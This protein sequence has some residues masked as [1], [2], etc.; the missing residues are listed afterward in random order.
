MLRL[1]IGPFNAGNPLHILPIP[2]RRFEELLQEQAVGLGAEIRR[3]Q[4]VTGFTQD[5]DGVTVD[6]SAGEAASTVRARFLVG[7]DGA[8]SLVRK[9]AGIGFPG[10]TSDI[11]TRI[12]RVT[13]PPSKI[14]RTRDRGQAGL[15]IAGVGRLVTMTMNQLPGGRFSIAPADALDRTAPADL[16]IIGVHEP[17]HDA[18]T[19]AAVTVD[20]LRASLRRVLGTDLPFTEATDLRSTIGN[21]RQ[22]DAYR[23]GHIFLAGD[24]A[25]VFNAG[26][27]SLN[28]GLQDA[29]DLADRLVAVLAGGRPESDLDGYH[30]ARHAAG[31]R[32]LHHTRA[33][34]A[35]SRNDD[36]GHALRQTLAPA[37]RSGRAA[38]RL[39]RLLEQA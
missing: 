13:I 15:D 29:L 27:T 3:G 30:T 39:A 32:A 5:D 36:V 16:Y 2:Q 7:C 28:I 12:A 34:A 17:R 9:R 25:H 31:L 6:L 26:G 24:A 33:Q 23:A 18:D 38:R 4:E 20:D 37:L 35:I 11:V 21:S 19:D 8:R 22:A 14:T 10:Y 1:G